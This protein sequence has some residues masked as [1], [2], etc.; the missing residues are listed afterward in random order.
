VTY[1]A[2]VLGP[3]IYMVKTGNEFVKMEIRMPYFSNT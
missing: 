3:G 2:K 1:T